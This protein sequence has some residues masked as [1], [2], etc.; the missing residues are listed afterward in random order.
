MKYSEKI[1]LLMKGVKFD[2]IKELEELEAKELEE[3]KA[4]ESQEPEENIQEHEEKSS[5][6]KTA[7][8][9]AQSMIKDLETKLEAKDD[10]L[11]KLNQQ[12]ATLNN[13]QTVADEP[14]QEDASDVMAQLFN[15]K[16]ED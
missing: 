3:A 11:A 5:E 4:N 15:N 1:Q 7:L 8:E 9:L 14:K 6:V 2:Q 12:F 16:K 13:K 10:E